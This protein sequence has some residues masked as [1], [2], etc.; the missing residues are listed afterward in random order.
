MATVHSS[1]R[2]AMCVTIWIPG[3][4]AGFPAFAEQAR[5]APFSPPRLHHRRLSALV[6]IDDFPEVYALRFRIVVCLFI[7]AHKTRAADV[8]SPCVDHFFKP[9]VDC[10]LPYKKLCRMRRILRHRSIFL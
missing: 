3:W 9:V 6:T 7:V 5:S 10:E 1:S 4:G 2:F 8:A